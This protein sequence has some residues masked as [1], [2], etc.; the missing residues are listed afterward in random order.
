[1]K[2]EGNHITIIDTT[3]RDGMHAVGHKFTTADVSKIAR[4]LETAD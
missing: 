4:A 1:M 3:C 2:R